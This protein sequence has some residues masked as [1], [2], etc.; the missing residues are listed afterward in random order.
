MRLL[1]L[2]VLFI[3]W[4][5]A[6]ITHG[7]HLWIDDIP[8]DEL[9]MYCIN[10]M[11]D[12]SQMWEQRHSSPEQNDT[13]TPFY[14]RKERLHENEPKSVDTICGDTMDLV[15]SYVYR[16]SWYDKYNVELM[17]AENGYCDPYLPSFRSYYRGWYTHATEWRI[18]AW[19]YRDAWLCQLSKYYKPDFYAVPWAFD[20]VLW[21]ADRCNLEIDIGTTFYWAS[22]IAEGRKLIKQRLR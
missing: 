2:I 6:Q 3:G 5:I 15:Y 14:D 21:Q 17:L 10:L 13:S 7:Q 16:T 18:P 19:V 20:N 9:T 22:R 4:L 8:S 12:I 11:E 1:L